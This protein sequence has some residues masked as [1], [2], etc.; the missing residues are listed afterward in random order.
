MKP[1]FITMLTEGKIEEPLAPFSISGANASSYT[2]S[3]RLTWHRDGD[4]FIEG[5]TS[6]DDL[7]LRRSMSFPLPGK[8]YSG[9]EFWRLKGEL[10]KRGWE[11][12]AKRLISHPSISFLGSTAVA[13]WRIRP[14]EIRFRQTVQ[15]ALPNTLE[16]IITPCPSFLLTKNSHIKDHNPVFGWSSNR[17][18]WW[19]MGIEDVKFYFRDSGDGSARLRISQGGK[20]FGSLFRWSTAFMTSLS[21]LYGQRVEWT[22]FQAHIKQTILSVLCGKTETG[23]APFP[24]L[25]RELDPGREND[26]EALLSSATRFF[27]NPDSRD[28]RRLLYLYW[29]S[30]SAFLPAQA[31]L[32]ATILEG[33]LRSMQES[34]TSLSTENATLAKEIETAQSL[35]AQHQAEFSDGFMKRLSGMLASFHGP[36]GRDILQKIRDTGCF[37]VTD[38]EIEA[39]DRIRN[40]L[41]HGNFS[42]WVKDIQSGLDRT[43]CIATLINKAIFCLI[44]YEGTYANYSERGYPKRSFVCRHSYPN[45]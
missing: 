9:E 14:G 30:F 41:S 13:M 15:K 7:L 21:F 44:G 25:S 35:L 36:R 26:R 24:P 6:C 40:P 37:P 16:G 28:V 1:E 8:I 10:P 42:Q 11:V 19:E 12:S 31:L 27:R 5:T 45:P 23:D 3:G 20:Q 18:D 17:T 32:M 29:G 2:G 34:V 4:I 43:A 39:W 22:G 38:G 33:L